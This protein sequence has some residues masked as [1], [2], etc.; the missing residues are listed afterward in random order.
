MF[1]T[2]PCTNHSSQR[3]TPP[4]T[5]Q[6]NRNAEC[7]RERNSREMNSPQNWR[8]PHQHQNNF[9]PIPFN[10]NI[11]PVQQYQNIPD[12]PF[13]VVQ[14]DGQQLYLSQGIAD[15]LRGLPPLV[16]VAAGHGRGRSKMVQCSF[17]FA[18][19]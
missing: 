13:Q 19:V 14:H 11:P 16:P 12:N 17:E 5:P 3:E 9:A 10:L 18:S 4:N 6:R 2:L 7:T 8:L 15:Q 1:D